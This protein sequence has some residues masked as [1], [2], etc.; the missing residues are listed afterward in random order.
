MLGLE[1]Q[2]WATRTFRANYTQVSV[3]IPGGKDKSGSNPPFN[4]DLFFFLMQ[5]TAIWGWEVE[6]YLSEVSPEYIL[7]FPAFSSPS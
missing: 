1:G 6:G 2:R 4:P 7:A 5:K 3:F